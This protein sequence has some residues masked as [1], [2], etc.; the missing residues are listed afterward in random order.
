MV[1]LMVVERY[2]HGSGEMEILFGT[3]LVYYQN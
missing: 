3:F 1:I 2:S